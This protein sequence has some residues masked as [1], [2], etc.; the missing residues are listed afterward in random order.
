MKFIKLFALLYVTSA[1]LC[2]ATSEDNSNK[3]DACFNTAAQYYQVPKEILT[4]I[5]Y[6]ESKFN[7]NEYNQNKNGTYDIGLMQINSTWLPKLA[8]VGISEQMLY[9]PC[10]SIY[11]GA[12][13][14]A[15]NIKTYG[16]NWTAV[17][18][19]NGNDIELK[20]ATKIYNKIQDTYPALL[21]PAQ[22]K[23]IPFDLKSE[24]KPIKINVQ[25]TPSEVDI[26]NNTQPKKPSI[27]STINSIKQP[28][29]S[30]QTEQEY[31]HEIDNILSKSGITISAKP[32]ANPEVKSQN[33]DLTNEQNINDVLRKS[34][35]H[36]T[37]E[38]SKVVSNLVE[39]KSNNVAEFNQFFNENQP[40][41]INKLV[42]NMF[43]ADRKNESIKIANLNNN[44]Q[45]NLPTLTL[46]FNE[47][48]NKNTLICKVINILK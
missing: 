18:R 32:T 8:T 20:Y 39:T 16:L 40:K 11:M 24:A 23:L 45:K 30:H 22:A 7:P 14:L 2:Y 4:A 46:D 3:Y 36:I 12:W 5:A 29:K 44:L 26:N 1:Q 41:N 42:Y 47:L 17:Q 9:E 33:N 25:N 37:P 27:E 43:H 35:V 31:A 15:H 28:E 6:V 10:Q 19:Y 48:Y 38:N 13:V 34:G 21:N